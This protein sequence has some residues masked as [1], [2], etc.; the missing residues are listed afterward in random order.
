MSGPRRAPVRPAV[1]TL[2]ACEP[3]RGKTC[4]RIERSTEHGVNSTSTRA[5]SYSKANL[6]SPS[7]CPDVPDHLTIPQRPGRQAT[8]KTPP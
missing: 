3:G 6:A 5:F 1:A 8:R 7:N 2:P 4:K